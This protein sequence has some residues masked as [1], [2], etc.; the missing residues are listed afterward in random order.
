MEIIVIVLLGLCFGSFINA[1]VWRI[2]KKRNFVSERSECTHCHHVL[3]WNDLIPVVSWVMLRGKC[4]YCHKKIDDSPIVELLTA[5]AF[6]VSYLA[7]PYGFEISGMVLFGLWL[8]AL[9]LLVALAVY[10]SRWY[11]LPDS[12]V[13]PLI[14]VG[15]VI[16]IT[17][18]VFV[19]TMV[20]GEALLNMILGVGVISGLYFALYE[21]S[22][23]KWVGFGDVKLGV[24]IGI[25]LGW[26]G[27]LLTLFLA[28]L[29]GLLYVLP[30]LLLN[31]VQPSSKIPFG[32][33]L[34]AACFITFLWGQQVVEWYLQSIVGI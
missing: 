10:D 5:V 30:L 19:E 2:H 6:V 24:F 15:V 8:V 11:L 33:F 25:I 3:A 16:G 29:I 22:S 34:I 21:Y 1:L 12:M 17:R 7:W 28:N 23:G 32:P 4:R 13:F 14:V 31:K 26:Q 9:V 20:I 27:A 18:F